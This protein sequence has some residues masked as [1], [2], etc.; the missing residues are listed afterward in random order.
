MSARKLERIVSD[1]LVSSQVDAGT[2][3]LQREPADVRVLV[4]SAVDAAQATALEQ[5]VELVDETGPE[6]LP[7]AC[8]VVRVSQVIDNLLSNALKYTATGGL[9]RVAAERHVQD[10]HVR[11][12]D[13]GI[14]I[15]SSDYS[16]VFERFG[17]T[18]AGAN[19]AAGTGLGLSIC[20]A[21]VEAHGGRIWVESAVGEGSTFTFSLPV[22]PRGDDD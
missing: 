14:G 9:V 4:E 8:D 22:R 12:T 10:V 2:L 5:G 6:P 17:R 1:L 13:T 7:A 21:I 16:R 20:R 18:E 3:R 11:V 15:A 19:V